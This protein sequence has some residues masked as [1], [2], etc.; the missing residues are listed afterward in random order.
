MKICL[1]CGETFIDTGWCCPACF[2][3]PR[4]VDGY[5]SFAP[6]Q[7]QSSE[8]FQPH[9][10]AEL[11]HAEAEN[12]WF[13]SRNRL[14][15]WALRSFFPDA[16]TFLEIGCGTGFVLSGIASANPCLEVSGSEIHSAGLSFAASRVERAVLFQMDARNIPF[17]SEFDV[18]G[19]FDVLEHIEEDEKVL[20]QI[21]HAVS[22]GGGMILTVPQHRFLWSQQDEYACHVRRYEAHELS[23]KVEKAGFQVL[24]ATSFVSLLL[25]LMFMSRLS[26]RKSTGDFDATQEFR[27]SRPV[28]W[29]LERVLD[30]ERVI[31][32]GGFSFPAG[33]SRL[34]IARKLKG[35]HGYP[36]Q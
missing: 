25:P 29:A 30:L 10:F 32:R 4:Q 9:H 24:R 3:S 5:L 35:P 31:I 15:I 14:I 34:L 23:E 19:A 18:I 26:K 36:V 8:G 22:P 20:K 12:F 1:S 7:A 16:R 27:I 2:T 28:N 21:F 33:G 11:A 6:E 13:R 17:E